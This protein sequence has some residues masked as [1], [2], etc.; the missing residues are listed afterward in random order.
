MARKDYSAILEEEISGIARFKTAFLAAAIFFFAANGYAFFNAYPLH[1]GVFYVTT[2]NHDWQIA[3]GR[4]LIPTY[5][6]LRGNMPAPFP[7]LILSILYLGAS[8]YLVCLILGLKKRPEIVLTCAFLSANVAT[9]EISAVHQYFAD[10]FLLALLLSCLAVYLLH[11]KV[12]AKRVLSAFALFFLSFG[13]YPAYF[14]FAL[15]L[16]VVLLLRM[17]YE[18]SVAEEKRKAAVWFLTIALA[19]A[20][21]LLASRAAVYVLHIPAS[22][23]RQS[24]FSLGKLS[25]VDTVISIARNYI[26]FIR[27]FFTGSWL[28]WPGKIATILLVALALGLFFFRLPSGKTALTI[29]LLLLF[30]L[31]SR[32]VNI[33]TRNYD[34]YRT[35]YTQ[36]LLFPILIWLFSFGARKLEKETIKKGL[37]LL[38]VFLSAVILWRNIQFSNY[39]F[40]YQQI[41]YD[42]SVQHVGVV[43]EDLRKYA[44]DK[45][46]EPVAVIGMF[47]LK[48]EDVFEDYRN[49]E[50]FTSYT[51]ITYEQVFAE[52]CSRLGYDLNWSWSKRNSDAMR[53]TPE[54][55]AMPCYPEEGYISEVNGY[56]VIKLSD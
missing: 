51:G 25:P 56:L 24:I 19:G 21:Y 41:L 31:G 11:D 40:V 33:M 38:F 13:L 26:G 22:H 9:F 8:E 1:D 54:V 28:G 32:L 50:G 39:G 12:S 45:D 48:Q 17:V 30:P 53:D 43:M 36:F 23:V 5:L 2:R 29:A 46:N 16:F 18:G 55:E 42:R 14:T 3:L 47:Q 37:T 44:V 6:K 34:S 35:M 52:F 27:L 49:I 15:C 7:I 10:I 4:F 20:A